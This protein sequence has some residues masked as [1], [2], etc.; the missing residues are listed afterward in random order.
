MDKVLLEVAQ[1]VHTNRTKYIQ[2]GKDQRNEQRLRQKRRAWHWAAAL[3]EQA[4]VA[5]AAPE[6][7]RMAA[8]DEERK[9]A[10]A[11][12]AHR[13]QQRVWEQQRRVA[14]HEREKR[15]EAAKLRAAERMADKRLAA[16]VWNKK[17]VP[18]VIAMASGGAAARH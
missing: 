11:A 6:E 7:E 9:A 5:A 16:A 12:A 3:E 10:A 4:R 2:D 15:D 8:A 1:N 14:E 13:E 18:R 17:H